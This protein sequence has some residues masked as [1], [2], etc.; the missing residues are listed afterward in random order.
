MLAPDV[1]TSCDRMAEAFDNLLKLDRF[2]ASG[3][4]ISI[5]ELVPDPQW[6]I[7]TR[8]NLS[9]VAAECRKWQLVRPELWAGFIGPLKSYVSSFGAFAETFHCTSDRTDQVVMLEAM[10]RKL[11]EAMNEAAAMNYLFREYYDRIHAVGILVSDI[12]ER[13][14][15]ELAD[16]Y[17]AMIRVA[18][19]L[20][21][22]QYEIEDLQDSVTSGVLNKG[23]KISKST[24]KYIYKITGSAGASVPYMTFATLGFTVGKTLYDAF[25]ASS[26]IRKT[27]ERIA[28]AKTRM[29]SLAQ[30]TACT[31]MI[32]GTMNGMEK[33]FLVVRDKMEGFREVWNG[34]LVKM[35]SALNAV[36]NGVDPAHYFDLATIGVAYQSWTQIEQIAD[37]TFVAEV[38]DKPVI[39]TI[40]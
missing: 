21:E 12:I 2:C 9:L 14:W 24:V 11:E 28:E 17:Q 18:S 40:E 34:E 32:I 30:A 36:K 37:R 19:G 5:A 16:Q 38:S 35:R 25:S 10:Y 7:G 20:S 31:R 1:I 39:V 8:Y 6:L 23:T 13:G 33:E 27:A 26:A 3:N 22:L 4:G 15:I 29:S